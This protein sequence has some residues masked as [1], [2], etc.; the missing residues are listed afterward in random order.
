MPLKRDRDLTGLRA[1]TALQAEASGGPQLPSFDESR[2]PPWAPTWFPQ[3]ISISL[4]TIITSNCSFCT[5][6][7]FVYVDP[8][9]L[10]LP[11]AHDRFTSQDTLSRRRYGIKDVLNDY[12][13]LEMKRNRNAG[14]GNGIRSWRS[15]DPISSH[16]PYAGAHPKIGDV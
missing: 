11:R 1:S 2:C 14:N 5:I 16:S 4:K 15:L 8:F 9:E 7:I 12:G 13:P 10:S 6:F 3:S